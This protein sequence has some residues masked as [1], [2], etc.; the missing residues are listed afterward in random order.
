MIDQ[1]ADVYPYLA[2]KEDDNEETLELTQYVK[3]DEEIHQKPVDCPE[4]F[5]NVLKHCWAYHPE[6][7]I[8]FAN[9]RNEMMRLLTF[10]DSV[11]R[12]CS[13][14]HTLSSCCFPAIEKQT[15]DES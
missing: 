2:V 15:N 1:D 12:K 8:S 13:F 7:R 10:Q 11:S 3:K 9:L 4:S 14:I 6:N 5:Y